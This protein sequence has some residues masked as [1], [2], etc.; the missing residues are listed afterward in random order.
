MTGGGP[1]KAVTKSNAPLFT[2]SVNFDAC[3]GGV[4]PGDTV[5]WQVDDVAHYSAL[6]RHF[7]CQA[8]RDPAVRIIYFRFAEHPPLLE[9]CDGVETVDINPHLGFESFIDR[10]LHTI[11]DAGKGVYYL[12]DSISPLAA[13]WYS[14]Q[15][16]GNFFMIVCPYLHGRDSV[17]HFSIL[18]NRHSPYALDPVMDT[19][20]VVLDVYRHENA[21]YVQPHKVEGRHAPRMYTL[22]RWEDGRVSPVNDSHTV[23]M[24]LNAA[25]RESLGLARHHLGVWSRTFVEA[26]AL[27]KEA[28]N[29]D[30]YRARVE[31]MRWRILRMAV[32][33]D[34]RMLRL[35]GKYFTLGD[36][37]YLGTRMLGTGLIGGKAVDLLLARNILLHE[38][39]HWAGGLE[40]HD[41]FFIPSDVFYTYLVQSGCWPV[42]RRLLHA[43]NFLDHAAEAREKIIAGAFPPHILKRFSDMLDY[44]GQSPVVVRS[45]S[46]L[47]DSFGNAFSG[48][49]ES[50]FCANQGNRAN[51]LAEFT[52]AVKQV[53]ASAM[54]REA[55]EYRAEHGL[56]E[57]DEQMAL[58]VQRVCGAH[59]GPWYFPQI[60]AVAFSF[61]PYVWSEDINPRAGVLRL[62][63]GLGTR[64]VDRADGDHTRLVAL[65]APELRPEGRGAAA[66][67]VSQQ[68]VDV[69]DL[70]GGGMVSMDFHRL[71]T[72]VEVPSLPLFAADDPALIRYA[73]ER[74]VN[75]PT[76]MRINFDGLLNRTDFIRDVRLMLD[77]LQAAYDHPV[78]VEFAA[79]FDNEGRYRI[80]LLQCRPL[81]VKGV[82]N[83]VLPP[84]PDAPNDLF[85]HARGP[86]I[87]RSRLVSIDRIIYVPAR[88]YSALSVQEQY[89]VA[90]T[91]GRLNREDPERATPPQTLLIGPGRWGSTIPALGVPVS[92][93]EISRVSAL[94]ELLEMHDGLMPEVSL[95]THFFNDLVEVDMLY[96][97]LD[98][99]RKE[100]LFDAARLLAL[101]NQLTSLLPGSEQQAEVLHVVELPLEDGARA[102]LW[103]DTMKQQVYCHFTSV[104]G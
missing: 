27:L 25:R 11:Q 6:I 38:D 91:I 66:A 22:H 89:A 61:N 10:M 23:A 97:A 90:R 31:A 73:R 14:D 62:V 44:F 17:A 47:E 68:K 101:P 58:V 64:A 70:A 13:D 75:L 65:N 26:E 71:I 56:L 2:G 76:A 20:R 54:S 43:E 69:L 100:T 5:V 80:A 48:K 12:F 98:P 96:L 18:R 78:D 32:S 85:L 41:S 3:L 21:L 82:D 59:H 52:Q 29:D 83:P 16:V 81:R 103:A 72:Q 37:V 84:P 36:L 50:V 7:A 88:V 92:F 93:S 33:R 55:L 87:G 24:V 102:S 30:S 15:M 60:A 79:N 42:R 28:G 45:S 40:M 1:K 35:A 95:G 34:E 63:F 9:G 104:N 4:R 19:A 8:A 94:C 51:R 77:T 46:L 67:A 39:P 57:S 53:Y 49:Y 99:A 74:G 86:V